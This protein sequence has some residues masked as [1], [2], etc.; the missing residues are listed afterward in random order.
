VLAVVSGVACIF[1]QALNIFLERG[2]DQSLSFLSNI[3]QII[4]FNT[5]VTNIYLPDWEVL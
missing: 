4:H 3:A 2:I 1:K 5:P